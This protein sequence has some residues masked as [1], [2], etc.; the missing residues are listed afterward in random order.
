MNRVHRDNRKHYLICRRIP[1]ASND[2]NLKSAT[3]GLFDFLRAQFFPT[4]LICKLKQ[5]ILEY[6]NDVYP[7]ANVM[8]VATGMALRMEMRAAIL[9]SMMMG[10]YSIFLPI[11]Q[12][13]NQ[14][15]E[16]KWC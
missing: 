9:V 11:T 15:I 13:L 4:P 8:I 1:F 5:N 16:I 3:I 14:I 2:A 10:E 12:K 7:A 6:H